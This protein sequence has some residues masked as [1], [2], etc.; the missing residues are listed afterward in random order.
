M[1][2]TPQVTLPEETE[3][4]EHS[5][6]S[7]PASESATASAAEEHIRRDD[8]KLRTLLLDDSSHGQNIHVTLNTPDHQWRAHTGRDA[9]WKCRWESLY[10]FA[11]SRYKWQLATKS[12]GCP[13]T[14]L[15]SN[16]DTTSGRWTTDGKDLNANVQVFQLEQVT[17]LRESLATQ[18]KAP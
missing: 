5:H 15:S 2:Y 11:E 1:S 8:K 3:K 9:D 17:Y 16:S 10:F 14:A 7:A 18:V 12:W 13:H 4:K 6:S